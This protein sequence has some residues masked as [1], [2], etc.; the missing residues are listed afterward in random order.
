ML[1]RC[2]H[3]RNSRNL[4]LKNSPNYRGF[5]FAA[6][7]DLELTEAKPFIATEE[8]SVIYSPVKSMLR[9]KLL[10]F[11]F[12]VPAGLVVAAVVLAI[13]AIP[14]RPSNITWERDYEKAIGRA[15]AEKKLIIADMFT[16]WCTLCKKMDAETFAE[17][18]L[19]EKMAN[20][21]VWLKL[22]TETEEDGIRLQKDFA[23]L[24]YPTVLVL[25]GQGEEV[26]RVGRFLPSP[27]FTQTVESFLENPDSLGGL[28]KAVLKQPNSVSARYA[29]AEKLLNQSNYVKAAPE[30]QKVIEL[31]PENRE[32]KTD[33]SHYNV[34]L[35]LASQ[36]K[37]VEAIAELDL[38]QTRFPRSD[39]VAD[40]TVL[41]GQ[42]YHCCNKLNE[43][44][45]VLREYVNKYPTHGHIQEVEN[46]LA[47]MDSA[48]EGK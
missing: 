28:R 38:L 11:K 43:A 39:A 23:I 8:F 17:P 29:L 27:Q 15:R 4:R 18:R 9:S 13:T 24:T 26:D 6:N 3:L 10:S 46:L 22:N 33:L 16:D 34:A 1:F 37:F 21:Y 30:F 31:D 41:R 7:I 14:A 48:N 47:I 45:A 35:S 19:I 25:D 40:A 12:L 36:E 42:I 20:K 44:Q 32:G 5:R 2:A